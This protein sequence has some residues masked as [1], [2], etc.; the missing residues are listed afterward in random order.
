MLTSLVEFNINKLNFNKQI[1]NAWKFPIFESI[2][3]LVFAMEK[4]R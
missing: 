4:Q 1:K 2:P 3:N